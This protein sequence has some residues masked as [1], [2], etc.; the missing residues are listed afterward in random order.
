MLLHSIYAFSKNS[1]GNN[2]RSALC[3]D[4]Y[5]VCIQDEKIGEQ[6]RIESVKSQQGLAS[7]SSIRVRQF[8]VQGSR[9]PFGL[10]RTHH[11]PSLGASPIRLLFLPSVHR[12]LWV[13]SHLRFQRFDRPLSRKAVWF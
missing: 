4:Y 5:K 13:A 9:F 3:N 2:T 12:S 11:F 1:M 7:L 6:E 10:A 8:L